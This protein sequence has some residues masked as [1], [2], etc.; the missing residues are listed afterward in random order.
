MFYCMDKFAVGT[1]IL[2]FEGFLGFQI[3]FRLCAVYLFMKELE[4]DPSVGNVCLIVYETSSFCS[5]LSCL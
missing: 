3:L 5:W 1:T 2:G 4:F